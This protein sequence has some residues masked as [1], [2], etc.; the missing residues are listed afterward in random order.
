MFLADSMGLSSQDLPWD[1]DAVIKYMMYGP[2]YEVE[3][4]LLVVGWSKKKMQDEGQK[5]HEEYRSKYDIYGAPL[6]EATQYDSHFKTLMDAGYDGIKEALFLADSLG[7][8]SQELPWDLKSIDEFIAK[9]P[10]ESWEELLHITGWEFGE[11]L[12]ASQREY[13]DYERS[14]GLRESVALHE[15]SMSDEE[16][17]IMLFFK[18]SSRLGIQVA[19]MTPGFEKLAEDLD[20][21]RDQVDC[22]VD[23]A[24]GLVR[25]QG[26]Y[27]ERNQ[28]TID[29]L[30]TLRDQ[31]EHG[32][33][34]LTRRVT[35]QAGLAMSN[36]VD[37]LFSL[38]D[39]IRIA[40]SPYS[41]G[42]NDKMQTKLDS[43]KD[44]ARAI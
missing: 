16:K 44:W 35:G 37:E 36:W 28:Y 2:E 21:F 18:E 12:A 17:V 20:N 8:P 34:N 3:D 19:E 42:W 11:W 7:I 33:Y 15:Q 5:A 26:K 31:I 13:E 4:V 10:R 29:D 38:V 1:H 14:L 27:Q 43:L 24:E 23:K 30:D 25:S 9:D 22:F 41:A 6:Q 39:G 32:A 40:V